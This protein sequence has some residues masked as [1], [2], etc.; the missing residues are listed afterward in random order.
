MKQPKNIQTSFN[1]LSI[2]LWFLLI[3]AVPFVLLNVKIAFQA[4][5]LT[6]FNSHPSSNSDTL[7]QPESLLNAFGINALLQKPQDSIVDLDFIEVDT[8]SGILNLELWR[9][10]MEPSKGVIALFHGFNATKTS[11][12]KEAHAFYRMGYTVIL[13]DLRGSG[14]SAG[15]Q[16]TYGYYEAL[17]IERAF[18]YCQENFPR[19]KVFLYGFSS[20]AVSIMRAVSELHIKPDGVILQSPY[21]R[22]LKRSD[23]LIHMA[24]IPTYITSSIFTFWTGQLNGFN[25]FVHD[26][27]TYAQN[28]ECPTLLIHG[29]N[30]QRIS[31]S[32]SKKIYDELPPHSELGVFSKSGHESIL[33]KEEPNWI[34]LV[35]NFMES[36]RH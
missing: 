18:H 21:F 12:W 10:D 27:I 6:H 33:K 22:F 14:N 1:W 30:D 17:D 8:I 26:P 23:N 11:L 28:I 19:K 20:G 35:T 24:P 29:M 5:N 25:A 3:M 9:F 4:Y 31:Y 2:F 34:Y 16:T 7:T 36:N 32:D 15:F 13:V